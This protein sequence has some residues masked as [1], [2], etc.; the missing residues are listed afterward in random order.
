[1]KKKRKRSVSNR[2]SY[3]KNKAKKQKV[4][5]KNNESEAL[6]NLSTTS[7]ETT[8][9]E[10]EVT[11]PLPLPQTATIPL[12]TSPFSITSPSTTSVSNTTSVVLP[13]ATAQKQ[14]VTEAIQM[15]SMTSNLNKF[16]PHQGHCNCYQRR[17]FLRKQNSLLVVN[18]I[19][20]HDPQGFFNT[21]E[22]TFGQFIEKGNKDILQC[23]KDIYNDFSFNNTSIQ[24]R[25]AQCILELNKNPRVLVTSTTVKDMNDIIERG[26]IEK[27]R[28]TN[29]SHDLADMLIYVSSSFFKKEYTKKTI[30]EKINTKISREFKKRGFE[31]PD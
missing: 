13:G 7:N 26:E 24:M 29:K 18:D 1:M 3:E 20:K 21:G 16:V 9:I 14:T 23:E 12:T 5:D 27:D 30:M 15:P 28:I 25:C 10:P 11:G 4:S 2:L 19:N 8:T 6:F 22:A 17:L 31:F